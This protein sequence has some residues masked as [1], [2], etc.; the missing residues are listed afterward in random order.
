MLD[1]AIEDYRKA[2]P[3]C[4]INDGLP[5]VAKMGLLDNND[6]KIIGKL[7]FF[8]TQTLFQSND[9]LICEVEVVPNLQL[10]EREYLL[11]RG[12]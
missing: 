7:R 3:S 1:E 10:L 5:N 12:F 11:L 9:Y 2:A 6:H 8:D 4:L